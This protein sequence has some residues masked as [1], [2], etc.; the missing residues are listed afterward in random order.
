MSTPLE[1]LK[2]ILSEN[3]PDE[4]VQALMSQLTSASGDGSVAITGDATGALTVTGNKNIAGDN[5]RVVIYQG[6]DPKELIE[7]VLS[8]SR[9]LQAKSPLEVVPLEEFIQQSNKVI[10]LHIFQTVR[11]WEGRDELVERLKQQFFIATESLFS[12]DRPKLLVLLGQGGIGKTSLAAKLLEKIGVDLS[13]ASILPICPYNKIICLKA[14][15]GNS[16]DE[17]AEFLIEKLEVLS[18]Q[19]LNTEEQKIAQIIL[20]LQQEKNLI[21]IDEVEAWLNPPLHSRA[22]LT[23][24]T[25]LGNLIYHLA[26]SNHQSQIIITSREIP[27]SL[28][29]SRYNDSQPDPTLVLIETIGGVSV[30]A[31]IEILRKRN[32]KDSEDDLYW[33]AKQ[34]DGHLFLLTQLASISR[35][36]PGYLRKHPELVT[37]RVE[38]I[39]KEQLVRQGEVALGLLKRMSIL[40]RSINIRGLTFLRLY[41]DDWMSDARNFDFKSPEFTEA[42]ITTTQAIIN[43]LVDCSLVDDRY[44]EQQAELFYDLH[45]VI[46][47]F[48]QVEYKEELPELLRNVHLF[49]QANKNISHPKN[50]NILYPAIE[51]YF[52]GNKVG[53]Y[54]ESF[55]LLK[56]KLENPLSRWG[57]WTLLKEMCEQILPF[58]EQEEK[59]SCLL[60]SGDVS[61]EL[62]DLDLAEEYFKSAFSIAQTQGNKTNSK[63]CILQLELIDNFRQQDILEENSFK[64]KLEYKNLYSNSPASTGFKFLEFLANCNR[65]SAVLTANTQRKMLELQLQAYQ[66]FTEKYGKSDVA[67]DNFLPKIGE[68]SVKLGAAEIDAGNLEIA[69]EIL[70]KSLEIVEHCGMTKYI[71]LTNYYLARIEYYSHNMDSAQSYYEIAC[72]TLQNLGAA[73]D[74]RNIKQEWQHMMNN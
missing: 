59:L 49:Y 23:K 15:D 39:L 37:Q 62:G 26:Y 14:Q 38:P 33:V 71:A 69:R 5:N 48:L 73:R 74:L 72:I 66:D 28:A 29:D 17:I 24:I 41:S 25:A 42:D 19:L 63:L 36:K 51:A 55:D 56:S 58:I 45:R 35:G 12:I 54:S 31:G 61:K 20:G 64:L 43:T 65:Q 11:I 7:I 34:V 52:F 50:I 30:D 32:L 46:K 1:K 16:F 70:Q 60:I 2:A 4:Q 53:D 22:G 68:I 10:G 67:D 8:R 40:R 13:S 3:F 47:E 27:A 18:S 57:Y 9:M 44:D 6:I 21:L